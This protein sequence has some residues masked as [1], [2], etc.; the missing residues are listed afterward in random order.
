MEI[1]PD[2]EQV[3]I[4]EHPDIRRML[5]W[6]KSQV[7]GLRSLNYYVGF[8][9]DK[10]ALASTSEEEKDELS[11]LIA[12]FIPVCK[13]YTTE[14]AWRSLQYGHTDLRRFRRM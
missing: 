3:P 1:H 5:I 14:T 7:E 11:D 10:A 13:A 8:L 2:A 4:I 12:L 6:M 9:M